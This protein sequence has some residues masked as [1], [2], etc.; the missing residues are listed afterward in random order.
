MKSNHIRTELIAGFTTFLTMSYILF[1]NPSILATPGTGMSFSGVMTATVLLSASMTLLMGLYARLPFAVAPGMGLNAFFTF[2]LILGEGIPWQTA[3]GM[4]FWSGVFFIIISATPLRQKLAESLPHNIKIASAV[5]IGLFLT[6]IGLKNAGIVIAD[7]ATFVRMGGLKGATLLSVVGLLVILP[8]MKRKHPLAFLAGIFV[9]TVSGLVMGLVPPPNDFFA[10]PD[11]ESVFMKMDVMSA[12]KLSL[13][14]AILSMVFTDMFDSISTFVGVS[15]AAGLVDERGNPLR[16]KQALVVD[17]IATTLSAPLGTSAG[18]AYIESAAGVEAG[19][20]TGL[21]S[22]FT[23]MFF[24][25]CLFLAPL[26][27]MVPAFATAPVLICVGLLMFKNIFEL[28]TEHFEDWVPAVITI[29][30]IP[31]TFSITKGL[32]AGLFV[33]VALYIM[34]GRM[35]E[36][37]LAL[38]LLGI[39][40]AIYLAA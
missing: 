17:A 32:M 22:V 31:L 27:G 2:T 39:L 29:I 16:M 7:P 20:R 36:L 33:Q 4:V 28:K 8:L 9:V 25:P 35:K 21:T 19:G 10:A 6:F 3:L 26:V 12:L 13:L 37:N 40:S 1:V 15:R 30:L 24:V 11:F 5:G 18:T 14:P 34:V 38:W 23:A